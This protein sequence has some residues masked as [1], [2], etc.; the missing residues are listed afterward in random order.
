MKKKASQKIKEIQGN[1]F[2]RKDIW[3]ISAVL[4]ISLFLNVLGFGWGKDGYVP[5]ATDS[6]E[7]VTVV[8][9][10]PNLFGTWTNKYPRL[11]FVIDGLCYKPFISSW[12]TNK[13][14]VQSNGKTANPPSTRSGLN[15]L[16]TISRIKF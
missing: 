2:D 6:I 11:Q 13:V 12:E 15:I 8:R 3:F 16:A 4:G 14:S 10:L 9:D 7:G 1:R 5:W